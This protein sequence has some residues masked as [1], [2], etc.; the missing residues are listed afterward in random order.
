[1]GIFSRIAKYVE[2]KKL[3]KYW[4]MVSRIN[5]LEGD[6]ENLTDAELRAKTDEFKERYREG[7]TLDELLFEAF[8]VVREAA[9]R[10]LNMRH[11][12][13]QLIGGIVLHEGKIAEMKTGEGK[14]LVATMPAYL[15]A[16]TGKNV[17][18]V[19]VNDYLAKRDATWMGPIY[20]FLGLK[21][22]Y[23]QNLMPELERKQ[24][25]ECDIV[26]GTNSEFGF[27]Y[28]RDN[29]VYTVDDMVQ[30][31]HYYAI[32]DEVDSILIDEARTPLIISGPSE[33]SADLY[34]KFA[35]FVPR[36]KEGEDYEVD[37][38]TRTVNITLSGIAKV[39]REFGVKN[40]Y[41]PRNIKLLNHLHQA[42][43]AHVF[44]KRDV[45]YVVKDG[46]VIIVDEFTGRLMYG[47]RY[48][49]G[50]HQAIEAK[51]GV[52]IR[53]ENQTLAT[54][55]LQN[56][57]RMYEKLAGMTGTAATEAEEFRVI[58]GL[59]VV[60]IPTNRPM[61]RI[62]HEDVIY[63]T[64]KAKFKAV[65]EEVKRR[66]LKGQPVLVGT[67][68]IEKNELLSSMLK[69][70]GIPHQVL[71][72]KNHELEAQII[73][74][75]GRLGAVTVATNM[76][77][78]GVDIILGGNP[79]DPDE[80]EKV[81]QLGGLCVIGTERH[82]SRRIDNQLRGRS[83][84]QGDPGE[85]KFFVSLE[86]DLLKRFGYERVQNLMERLG[87]PDDT[88]I[89]HPLISRTIETAQKQIESYHFNIRKRLLEYDDVL[90]RQRE[91]IYGLRKKIILN[92][93]QDEIFEEFIDEISKRLAGEFAVK[94]TLPEE[95]DYDGLSAYL[96][97]NLGV[98][99][100]K[101]S[102]ESTN[103]YELYENI[104][105]ALIEKYRKKKEELTS[106]VSAEVE[107]IILLRT[108][109]YWWRE[110]LYDMDYLKEGINL[111]AYGQK[112]PLVEYKIEGYKL[113]QN[114][115]QMIQ[116]QSLM[117]FYNVQVAVE[118][119]SKEKKE[120]SRG[121]QKLTASSSRK[122]GRNDPCPCGSGL[123]YKKCCGRNL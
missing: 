63:K 51:E 119:I 56:Y 118:D 70:A 26:Y 112:D 50:L 97:E 12:D 79:P 58:Y 5:S 30:R 67:I 106:E 85:S 104:K 18:I 46:E 39:E 55:T 101:K 99:L 111:R 95:W 40:L 35:R 120:S 38:K 24:V 74:Q 36:L 34:I 60:V 83:G 14:T 53:E 71:N 43:R 31:G 100:D 45:D 22:G 68:S 47:R 42:L 48:S 49:E 21:V 109:D 17:H 113:F 77:G 93:L 76:A 57:F 84:R 91:A 13:V 96:K 80:A 7:E 54:I 114:T 4:E 27:D 6:F 11:F 110:H 9:K 115:M 37:H 61:I 69:K 89:E 90:N 107:R 25:Y 41:D 66:H 10:T 87:L 65:V 86:D 59:D 98:E 78:R 122:V 102:L 28:L 108:I 121:T 2:K 94:G 33:R 44:F 82:E 29:M 117:Y 19:T 88:P 81:R 62:D 3:D 16:L 8:A 75:A 1:M 23:L 52:L 20:E 72:A 105:S 103:E 64:E 32:V 116:E 123:K 73:A 15:N 92:G